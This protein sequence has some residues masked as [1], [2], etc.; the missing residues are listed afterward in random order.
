MRSRATVLPFAAALAVPVTVAA[1]EAAPPAV[2]RLSLD[3]ARARARSAAPSVE[4]ARALEEAARAEVDWSRAASRPQLEMS[5]G[6]TR[7]SDVPELTLALP[8]AA[9]RTIFP[10]IPD[11][12]RT[13]LDGRMPL[14]TGGRTA[15]LTRAAEAEAAAAGGDVAARE[16]D[17]LLETTRAYWHLVTARETVQVLAESLVAYEAHL[18]DARHRREAGLAAR[19]E[20]LAVEV[21]RDRAELARLRASHAAAVAEADLAR[22][23]GAP[24]SARIEP[25]HTLAEPDAPLPAPTP[26]GTDDMG[27]LTAEALSRRPERAALHERIAAADAR[28]EAE[29]AA[30]RPQVTVGAGFDYANPN[31]RILPPAAQWQDSWD[32]S[33]SLSWS[34][35]DGG[36]SAAAAR[37]AAARMGALRRQ[38]EDLDRRIRLEVTARALEV[39]AA[40]RA[41]AVAARNVEAARE[42]SRVASER[43]QAGVVPFSERLDAEVLH[44]RARLDHTEARAQ[45]R[46]ARA[47]LERARGR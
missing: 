11:N 31:R 24:P 21:E 14:Y 42:N 18:A 43:H 25:A 44:L 12:Y 39:E 47:A 4:E 34:L 29:R 28:V 41:V 30:R 32:V 10:N 37:R 1:Q 20:V 5:A 13:R 35:F 36:R 46:T 6:Y 2:L 45:L 3:E 8:G 23:V 22:L 33:L 38:A 16:A 40:S 7:L 26:P 15:A 27:T 17:L 19:N 9:P